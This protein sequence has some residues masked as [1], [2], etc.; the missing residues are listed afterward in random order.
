MVLHPCLGLRPGLPYEKEGGGKEEGVQGSR[1]R[2]E[3]RGVGGV[4]SE[5]SVL[6]ECEY[7]RVSVRDCVCVLLGVCFGSSIREGTRVCL[8]GLVPVGPGR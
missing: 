1:S 7:T 8:W 4:A 2:K 5:P 3:L 6:Y